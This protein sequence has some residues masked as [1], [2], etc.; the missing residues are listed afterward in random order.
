MKLVQVFDDFLT[1]QAALVG[2]TREEYTAHYLS[3][4]ERDTL[5]ELNDMTLGQ[6]ERIEDYAEMISERMESG[7][8]LE[9]WM[10]SQIT[11]ALD[12]LNAVHDAMDGVDGIEES[13]VN[14]KMKIFLNK[15]VSS[16]VSGAFGIHSSPKMRDELA[17]KI[18]ATVKEVLIKYDYVVESKESDALA[19]EIDKAMIKIDDSMSYK[20][21]ALAVG[22]ILKDEYGSHNFGPFME[23]LHKDLGI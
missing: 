12:N 13:N 2:M 9:S 11:I 6:L 5:A 22:K 20:D 18:E 14:E 8:Q 4:S 1:Q 21:F 19:K 15:I 23:I 7:Q 17:A 10:F 3:E 16:M